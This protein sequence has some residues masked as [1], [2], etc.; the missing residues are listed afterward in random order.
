MKGDFSLMRS[1]LLTLDNFDEDLIVLSGDSVFTSGNGSV[2]PAGLVVGE[3]VDVFRHPTGV[4]RYATV[5]PMLDIGTILHVFVIT[6][7][8]ITDSEEAADESNGG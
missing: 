8:N 2:F 5:K 4:G 6:D 1:G 7:F 3:V